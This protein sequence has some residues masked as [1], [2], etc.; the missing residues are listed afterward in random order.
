MKL[1]WVSRERLEEQQARCEKLE[2]EVREMMLLLLPGLR[3]PQPADIPKIGP[4][5][6]LS[7]VHIIP[8]RETIATL[9]SRA[10]L[11]AEKRAREGGTPI[12]QELVDAQLKGHRDYLKHG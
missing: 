6:D 4:D 10:T 11:A 5:T 3:A 9:R 1:P 8:G 2:N 12:P 7:K